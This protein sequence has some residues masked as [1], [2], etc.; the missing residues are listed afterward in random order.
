MIES[1]LRNSFVSVICRLVRCE[2]CVGGKACGMW[3]VWVWVERLVGCEGCV[4]VDVKGGICVC[5]WKGL[6]DMTGVCV[7]GKAC[8]IWQVCG[9]EERLVE[10]WRVCVC[11]GGKACGM[12]RVRRWVE[13]LVGC[14]GCAGGWKGL[15]DV[16]GM[17]VG[18]NACGM[19]RV[20]GWVERCV[21]CEGCGWVE[22]GY[23]VVM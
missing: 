8:G 2:G 16:K 23:E 13:R 15:W 22:M 21:G 10:M 18:G 5:R 12:W 17:W 4:C 11:V 1:V 9:W 6:W 20:C 3:W 19:W 7:G 14:E